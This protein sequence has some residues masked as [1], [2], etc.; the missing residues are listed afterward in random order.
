MRHLAATGDV[1]TASDTAWRLYLYWWIGGYLTEVAVWMQELL[2]S[3]AEVSPRT[4]AIAAFY[5]AW[6]DMWIAPSHE[7]TASLRAAAADF[8]T[9]GDE[10][11]A[12]MAG[13]TA[14]LAEI[15]TADPDMAAASAW[16]REGADRFRALGAGW[17]ETLALVALGRIATLRGD[18]AAATVEFERAVSAATASGDLFAATVAIHHLARMR[19][20]AGR[21][22]DSER[23]FL[24]A[25]EGSLILRHDEGIAYGLEGVSA[26]AAI[27]EDP[28]RA[29]VL[30]GAAAAIRKRA[31]VFDAPLFVFHER[32]L[33][34]LAAQGARHR[35]EVAERRGAEY[36]AREAAEYA[37]AGGGRSAKPPD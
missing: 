14:G 20:F 32:Y 18:I 19:L 22:E 26:I 8:A 12:T 30:A 34:V 24:D 35:I 7:I 6:R 9:A 1:E 37:L 13:A 3:R 11:G 15:N 21:V 4:R 36:G 2:T 28:E 10:V 33:E 17:G 27:R 31:A 29:G 25:I 16:L 23:L 5:V